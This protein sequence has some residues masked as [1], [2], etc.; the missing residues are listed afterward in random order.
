MLDILRNITQEVNAAS[1]LQEAMD[2]VVLRVCESMS[3]K[4]CSL[5]LRDDSDNFVLRATKGLNSDAIGRVSMTQNQGLVG[6]VAKRGEAINLENAEAHSRYLYFPETGEE[7]FASFLGVPVIHQR[8]VLGVLALQQQHRRRFD[9]SEEALMLTLS[10]Q[11]AAIIAHAKATG[12]LEQYA[13]GPADARFKGMPAV[14]GIAIGR[15]VVYSPT[16]DLTSV[17][18]SV[19]P[20]SI[21]KYAYSIKRLK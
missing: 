12:D 1:S 3:V 11:L 13:E 9:E 16:A 17:P 8:Q 7:R 15:A 2:L 21:A 10:A 19:L 14:N 18:F 6:Y 20:M 5:Y 4:V